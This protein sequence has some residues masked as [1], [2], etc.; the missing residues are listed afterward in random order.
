M[1]RHLLALIGGLMLSLSLT[2]S[3]GAQQ[4]DIQGTIQSQFDAFKADDF[5]TAF[6]YATPRLQQIFRNPQNFQQ[7]VTRG[8]PMVWKWGTVSF[9]DLRE[10]GAEWVQIVEVEDV[11]GA[12]HLLAYRMVE[13]SEGWRIGGVQI[14]DAPGVAA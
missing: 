6:T 11:G 5:E 1:A 14:L 4:S 12:M 3:A 2:F 8:Y 13:T 9:L 7:M 10:V